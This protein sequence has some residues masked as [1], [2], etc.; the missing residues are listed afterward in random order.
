VC[1]HKG[2][3]VALFVSVLQVRAALG[4]S[5]CQRQDIETTPCMTG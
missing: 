5:H 2:G 3:Y 1:A 4:G